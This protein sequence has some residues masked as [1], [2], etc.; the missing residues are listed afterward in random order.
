VDEDPPPLEEEPPIVT[1]DPVPKRTEFVIHELPEVDA[2]TLGIVAE[3][4]V[5][6]SLE[7]VLGQPQIPLELS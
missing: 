7:A 4:R 5:V 3:S 1:E 6:P 2:S